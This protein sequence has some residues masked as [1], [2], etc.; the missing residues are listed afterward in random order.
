MTST[1]T[2]KRNGVGEDVFLLSLKRQLCLP[3][4]LPSFQQPIN[5]H[6][7]LEL[8]IKSRLCPHG[9]E[10]QS[11]CSSTFCSLLKV[12]SIHITWWPAPSHQE[13]IIN[14]I[15]EQAQNLSS[16]PQLYDRAPLE[17]RWGS[18]REWAQSLDWGQVRNNGKAIINLRTL[19]GSDYFRIWKHLNSILKS[20]SGKSLLSL[21][22]S[23]HAVGCQ[24]QKCFLTE[25]Q[26]C[27]E[28]CL[29]KLKKRPWPIS[30]DSSWKYYLFFHLEGIIFIVVFV[31]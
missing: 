23:C 25:K 24:C 6:P 22:S 18:V 20:H 5:T 12:D 10:I 2:L 8:K 27:S 11:T 26:Q 15:A 9:L 29:E 13:V 21:L 7:N 3:K 4:A 19:D 1:M 28:K 14:C 16:S 31:R 30:L 17:L